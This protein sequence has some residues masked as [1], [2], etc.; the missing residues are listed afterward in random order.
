MRNLRNHECNGES[1]RQA[2]RECART[3]IWSRA[4]QHISNCKRGHHTDQQPWPVT[5]K[6]VNVRILPATHCAAARGRQTHRTHKTQTRG[7]RSRG[8][9]RFMFTPNLD[10]QRKKAPN[11]R[12]AGRTKRSAGDQSLTNV[13]RNA[14]WFHVLITTSVINDGI[15]NTPRMW[16]A[17]Q[18]K[19]AVRQHQGANTRYFAG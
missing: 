1:R 15:R 9:A 19:R 18:R 13:F 7:S 5:D 2:D 12:E 6:G 8:S 11:A 4:H 16:L 17:A 3:P 14:G 10:V